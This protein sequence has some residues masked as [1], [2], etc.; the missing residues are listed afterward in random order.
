LASD[1]TCNSCSVMSLP[2]RGIGV[3][4]KE[5]DTG[6]FRKCQAFVKHSCVAFVTLGEDCSS[7]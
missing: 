7:R 1:A 5:Q 6:T 2:F 4:Y 3:W